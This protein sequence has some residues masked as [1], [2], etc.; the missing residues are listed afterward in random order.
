MIYYDRH[1]SHAQS[2]YSSISPSFSPDTCQP[3]G[4][5][6]LSFGG[7][8][9]RPW[10]WSKRRA[11]VSRFVHPACRVTPVKLSMPMKMLLTVMCLKKGKKSHTSDV[12]CA[13]YC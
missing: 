7:L 6:V 9:S 10:A 12:A 5:I 11:A 13:T 4:L 2:T 3:Q 1:M 8:Y